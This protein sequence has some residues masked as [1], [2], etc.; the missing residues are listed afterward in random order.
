MHLNTVSFLHS[1]LDWIQ[2]NL[3]THV[4]ISCFVIPQSFENILSVPTF[5]AYKTQKQP[6]TTQSSASSQKE[7]I[8]F[9]FISSTPSFLFLK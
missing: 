5:K 1:T 4:S 8:P 3:Q 7:N 2:Y 6:L 9:L